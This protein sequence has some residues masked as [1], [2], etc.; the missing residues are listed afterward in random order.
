MLPARRTRAR[1][2]E[3]CR[4]ASP[5]ISLSLPML[6]PTVKVSLQP[7]M[8]P[9][10]RTYRR[11]ALVAAGLQRGCVTPDYRLLKDLKR[12]AVTAGIEGERTWL[13]KFRASR[14]SR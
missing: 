5:A 7:L 1:G 14:A 11:T 9:G 2:F 10:A 3:V 13:P 8:L 4:T 12:I 6:F